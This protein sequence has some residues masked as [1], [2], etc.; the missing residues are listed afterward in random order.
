MILCGCVKES[1]QNVTVI[2]ITTEP[3]QGSLVE[4]ATNDM[5]DYSPRILQTVE[6]DSSGK[7][8]AELNIIKPLFGYL[9][10]NDEYHKIYL[11]PGF[12]LNLELVSDEDLSYMKYSGVGEEIN[13]YL[14][15]SSRL[16][17]KFYAHNQN[18]FRADLADFAKLIEQL[19]QDIERFHSNYVSEVRLKADDENLLKSRNDLFFINL[20]QQHRLVRSDEYLNTTE[21]SLAPIL[22]VDVPAD[23]RF[24]ELA[25]IEYAM[26]L[27]L[28]L[29]TEI[30]EPLY[31]G[32]E[33]EQVDSLVELYPIISN[34]QIAEREF[35]D[36]IREFLI[37]KNILYWLA[38]EG[39]TTGIDSIYEQFKQKFVDS[40]YGIN[41][42]KE[43]DSWLSISKG[44]SAPEITGVTVEN[45]TI[46]LSML[47]G[48]VVYIDIWATWC[49]P[50]IEEFSYYDSLRKKVKRSHDVVFLFVSIDQDANKWS[51]FMK[52]KKTPQGI[53]VKEIEIGKPTVR[54]AYKIWGIPN[55]I[56]VDKEGRIV[57]PKAPRPSS[58]ESATLINNVLKNQ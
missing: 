42:D 50:C 44:R 47:K 21:A 27:D 24:I 49:V 37:A 17:N 23:Q 33:P 16:I 4:I 11:E 58:R 35:P 1:D 25:M 19:D 26:V 2:N 57:N 7:G 12:S 31:L 52:Q 38:S 48:K 14:S 6:L 39:I 51:G 15:G 3:H 30:Q 56:V 45:D 29:R 36:E 53:H 28:M 54:E 8:Y 5:L 43:Y 41:L 34:Q 20:K 55:Y 40:P 46:S 32:A 13:N 22:S 9:K 18:W 10:L